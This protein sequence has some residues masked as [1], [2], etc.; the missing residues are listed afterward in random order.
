MPA[1]YN[2]A[3]IFIVC[4][5]IT[6]AALT[7]FGVA[8]DGTGRQSAADAAAEAVTAAR[9]ALHDCLPSAWTALALAYLAHLEVTADHVDAAGAGVHRVG[10]V[11][12]ARDP[13]DAPRLEELAHRV[14]GEV[15]REHDAVVDLDLG[16][17]RRHDQGA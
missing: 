15:G 7:L 2:V 17:R 11:A 10:E 12:P 16:E 4:C 13:E 6:V 14:A 8:L 5:M 9:E 1:I 3:D